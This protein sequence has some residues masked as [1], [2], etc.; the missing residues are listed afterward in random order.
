MGIPVDLCRQREFATQSIWER[1]FEIDSLASFLRLIY[2]YNQ[3]YHSL[4]FLN[5]RIIKALKR[6][7]TTTEE[8]TKDLVF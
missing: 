6:I 2:E 5:L 3:R 1:K 4:D 7:M 8:Q